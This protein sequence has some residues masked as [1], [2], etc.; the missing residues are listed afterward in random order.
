[1][2]GRLKVKSTEQQ[3]AEEEAKRDDKLKT[4]Q[5][6]MG[7]I[8]EN[9]ETWKNSAAGETPNEAWKMTAGVLMANPD[10]Y[11]LWAIRKENIEKEVLI[12]DDKPEEHD[13]ILTKELDLTY[14]C[15]MKNPKSYGT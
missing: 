4:Y 9:R 10:I 13:T 3:K 2:H 7:K 5:Y 8:L 12:L 11:T 1:M 14:H 6:A 15:L